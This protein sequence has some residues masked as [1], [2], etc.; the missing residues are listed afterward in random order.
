MKVNQLKA[1][2]VLSYMKIALT[3]MV[4]LLYTP[5]IIRYLGQSE[6]GLYM[7]VTSVISMFHI[8]SLGF[9]NGYIRYYAKYKSNNEIEKINRLN[10]LFLIIFILIGIVSAVGGTFLTFNLNIIFS[11]GL[12]VKEYVIARWLM[13]L[14]TINISISFPMSVFS[15]IISANE[16]FV[17]LKSL[18]IFKTLGGPILSL[19]LL[20]LGFK[21]IA[22]VTVTLVI[23]FLI[24]IV[25]LFYVLGVL[26]NKFV[27]RG[28]EKGIF[29]GLVVYTSF[30]ALNSIVDQINSNIGKLL[31]GRYRGTSEVSV[32]SV[33]YTMYSCYMT[34]STAV[35]GI[36]TPKIHKLV[37]N[38]PKQELKNVLTNLFIKVGRL[39]FMI[40]GLVLSGFLFFGKP[41]MNIWAGKNYGDSYYVALLLMSAASVPLMQNLGIEIQRAQNKHKFRSIAYIFMALINFVV[42]IFLAQE[43]GAKGAA[44]GTVVSLI[45]ANGFIMNIYYHKK[46]NIDIIKFW[47]SI[48]RLAF[49]MTIP[50][51]GG[52]II[53]NVFEIKG[54]ISMA[55]GIAVYTVLYFVSVWFMG[56][57]EYEKGLVKSLLKLVKR[58]KHA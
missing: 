15:T 58:R 26:K 33:G 14:L 8:L 24:D 3:V 27:F 34:F 22:L 40:I 7:T 25:Y 29:G 16:R 56:M 23:A 17:F 37:N 9:N 53:V 49:S 19:P 13:L 6:Y 44:I 20:M 32:Y 47:K 11:S 51:V 45:V 12:T 5:A 50:V 35:S 31:L 52:L 46:C 2:S 57:N 21:S 36:F 42:T 4:N 54:I 38:T 18:S 55:I 10:G 30:I 39:Q 43:Y 1:G 48:I 28:F 41:F